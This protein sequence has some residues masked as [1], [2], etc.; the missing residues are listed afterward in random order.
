MLIVLSIIF[1]S[2]K[3]SYERPNK[4]ENSKKAIVNLPIQKTGTS[5][6]TNFDNN[7]V[8]KAEQK[9]VQG[10]SLSGII[11]HNSTVNILFGYYNCNEIMRNDIVAFNFS[12]NKEPIIKVIKGIPGDKFSLIKNNQSWN[13]LIN[14]EI[15]KNSEDRSYKLDEHQYKMLSLYEKDYKGTI[16]INAYLLMGNLEFGSLDSTRFGLVGKSAI[17]GKVDPIKNN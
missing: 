15:L 13:I 16:P 1:Y 5:R 10:N 7:C 14:N 11:E 9:I 6:K 12:G 3:I 17:L 4:G 2:F 8:T